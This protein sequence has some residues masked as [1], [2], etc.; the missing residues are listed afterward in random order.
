MRKI[1]VHT[2]YLRPCR[3]AIVAAALAAGL[4]VQTQAVAQVAAGTSPKAAASAA[5]SSDPEL[6]A[7]KLGTR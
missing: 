4:I 1:E 5:A 3:L 6:T 7:R 2:T